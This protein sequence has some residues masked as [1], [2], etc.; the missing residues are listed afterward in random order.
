MAIW[1]LSAPKDGKVEMQSSRWRIRPTWESLTLVAIAI[2]ALV[3]VLMLLP[4]VWKPP[5]M[6]QWVDQIDSTKL[7]VLPPALIVVLVAYARWQDQKDAVK[8]GGFAVVV[9]AVFVAVRAVPIANLTTFVLVLF[10]IGVAGMVGVRH[11]PLRSRSDWS[12]TLFYAGLILSAVLLLMLET[13]GPDQTPRYI[14]WVF[15]SLFGGA[16]LISLI[17]FVLDNWKG[18]LIFGV[19]VLLVALMLMGLWWI[20]TLVGLDKSHPVIAEA[21]VYVALILVMAALIV[22]GLMKGKVSVEPKPKPR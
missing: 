9:I 21:I 4:P 20:V 13:V 8:Y 7:S 12:R 5:F 11:I 17:L 14:I 1:T 2:L 18:T 19:C 6:T 10:C 22:A 3:E 16:V 15:L